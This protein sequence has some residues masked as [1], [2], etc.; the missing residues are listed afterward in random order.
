MNN[1]TNEFR[2]LIETNV[3]ISAIVKPNSASRRCINYVLDCHKLLIGSYSIDEVFRI[4]GERFP[5]A[6]AV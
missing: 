4:V 2:I 6:Q 1:T 3:F 5:E